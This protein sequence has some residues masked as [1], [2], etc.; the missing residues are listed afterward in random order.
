M[1]SLL[2]LNYIVIIV[3]THSTQIYNQVMR[4]VKNLFTMSALRV[5]GLICDGA[6]EHTKFFRI[7][8]DGVSTEDPDRKVYMNH[9][10]DSS[11]KIFSISDVPHLIKKGRG[12]LL[13]SGDNSWSTRRLLYG[14]TGDTIHDGDL[15][16]WDPLTWIH[17]ER[18]KKNAAGQHRCKSCS[19]CSVK[20]Y[21]YY[22]IM[23]TVFRQVRKLTDQ[24]MYPTSLELLRVNLA[25]VIFSPEV[26]ELLE[27]FQ[28]DV[29]NALG[30]ADLSPL[31]QYLSHFYELLQ[32][33]NSV[34]SYC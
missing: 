30:I 25:A 20:I 4:T 33:N 7:V 15:M 26:R 34:S 12:S 5:V 19:V 24:A 11:T 2:I 8:L 3:I 23:C 9:P 29:S 14:R 16:T 1:Y 32:L 21:L 17:E 13:R 27:Q 31:Q 28:E 10:C 22:Y 6:S 18:N